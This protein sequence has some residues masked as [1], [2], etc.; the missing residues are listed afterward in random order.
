MPG[1]LAFAYAYMGD[2]EQAMEFLLEAR[3]SEDVELLFLDD[4][5]LD[6]LRDDPRFV[7]LIRGMN[8]PED[9]YLTSIDRISEDSE[10]R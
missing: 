10:A 9:V 4:A 1:T 5:G 8:L 3:Q 7:Q 6:P 2:Y